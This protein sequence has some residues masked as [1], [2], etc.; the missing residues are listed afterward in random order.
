MT[1]RRPAALALL[2]GIGSAGFDPAHA[3][4]FCVDDA[5]ELQATL[6]AAVS[7]S[8]DDVIRIETGIYRSNSPNGFSTYN[9]TSDPHDLE[10]SGG[11][12]SNCGLRLPGMRSTIDGELQRPGLVLGATV[13]VRG[14]VAVRNMQFVNGYSTDPN[15][16]GGLT[17]NRG[18]NIVIE[19]NLFRGNTL[20]H[21]NTGA[22]AG[23][24][25]V[26][27]GSIT[28][29]GNL[30][31][32]ND[33]DS[34]ANPAAGAVS[35]GCYS[36]T[37][38]ANFNNNTVTGNTA[39]MGAAA[40]I[41][42]VRVFGVPNCTWTLANNILW[43]N[44]GLDLAIDVTSVT[45]RDNDIQNRGGSQ[46]PASSVGNVN[47]DPRFVSATQQRLQRSSPLV[48]AGI[49]GP[50]G[51]LPGSSFDGGPRVVGSIVDI[52]AYELDV[53]MTNGFDSS[54]FGR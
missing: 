52:G 22:A 6:E 11:W 46:S 25:A 40:D 54:A 36:F 13:D 19:S 26:S 29:R 30:F 42:G 23:L 33:A 27:E 41:G 49:N 34:T 21:D 16:A 44:D 4:T 50:V 51:G 35:M 43:G 7:N 47:V 37:Q 9:F 12:T 10:I 17:V 38:S 2:L 24:Y 48:D 14:Q 32:D 8:T 5:N 28:I 31:V 20:E 3:A 39:D 1:T 45:L 15:K 18:D 53:L